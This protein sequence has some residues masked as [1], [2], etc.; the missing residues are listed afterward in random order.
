MPLHGIHPVTLPGAIDAF[1]RLH[2]D[3]GSLPLDQILH[4]AITY[5]TDGI[6][7]APRTAY[8]WAEDLPTLQGRAREIYTINGRAPRAG[9]VFRH[10]GQAEVLRRIAQHGRAGFYEGEV[11]DDMITSLHGP[12]RHPH[13]RTTCRTPPAI[14][15]TPITRHLQTIWSCIEHPPNGQGATAILMLNI[16]KHFDL[17]SAGPLRPP[18]RPYRGRGRKAGL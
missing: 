4:P 7:V 18:A 16:L 13:P 9:E 8:D 14:T 2:A 5:A 3:H 15:P 11:A 1:C 10:P 12:W 6:P 17:A